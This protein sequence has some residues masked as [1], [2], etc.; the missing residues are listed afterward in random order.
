[1]RNTENNKPAIHQRQLYKKNDFQRLPTEVPESTDKQAD[2]QILA[3]MLQRTSSQTVKECGKG[4][5][6]YNE[7]DQISIEDDDE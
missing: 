1:M 7:Y 3:T 5:L 2:V 6:R 4:Q